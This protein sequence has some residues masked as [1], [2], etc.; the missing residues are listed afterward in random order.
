VTLLTTPSQKCSW[1]RNYS[2]DVSKDKEDRF[3]SEADQRALYVEQIEDMQAE[4][5]ALF[6]FTDHDHAAWSNNAVKHQHDD[7]FMEMIEQA[8]RQQQE[9]PPPQL[10]EESNHHQ[11]MPDPA[12]TT[13]QVVATNIQS[14]ERKVMDYDNINQNNNIL[15]HL[16]QDGTQVKMVD[17]GPKAVTSRVAVAESK[18]VFPP[19]VLEAFSISTSD[20][21]MIGPK[22]PIFATAKLAGIIAAK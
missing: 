3:L 2:K 4:R 10:E 7:D 8:R 18:V 13:E 9:Q 12:S 16:S 22:G 6:G 21:E 1:F 14:I 19:E 15:T 5:E 20:N 11:K 17:V